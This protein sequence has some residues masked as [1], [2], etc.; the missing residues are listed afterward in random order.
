MGQIPALSP[1]SADT[2]R[3]STTTLGPGRGSPRTAGR[4]LR[5]GE[6]M[7]GLLLSALSGVMLWVSWPHLGDLWWLIFI[8]FV[9]MLVAQYRLMPRRLVG[10]PFGA[11]LGSYFAGGLWMGSGPVGPWA[12]LIPGLVF[13]LLGWGIGSFDKRFS[14]RTGY[15]WLASTRCQVRP[16]PPTWQAWAPNGTLL[17]IYYKVHPVPAMGEWFN[18]PESYRTYYTDIGPL[19]MI[20][21]FDFDFPCRP[22][23]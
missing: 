17:G 11:A 23:W 19:S 3:P 10:L 16:R 9:P 13:G 12:L 2:T 14:E 6:V 20:I 4:H 21:C 5:R 22:A 8:A 7:L 15:R 18:T 1:G